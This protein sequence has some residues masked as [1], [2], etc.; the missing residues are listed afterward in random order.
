MFAFIRTGRRAVA[1]L[2]IVSCLGLSFASAEPPASAPPVAGDRAAPPAVT[3]RFESR[4]RQRVLTLW[5]TPRERGFAHGYLLADD[6][7][8]GAEYDFGQLLKPML[9]MY[10]LIVRKSLVSRFALEPREKDELD[11]L[12]EGIVA[13]RGADRMRLEA[14]GRDLD[15]ADLLALNT[16]GDWYGMGCSSLAVWGRHSRDGEPRV[17][18]NFDFPAFELVTTYALT[19]VRAADDGAAGCVAITYP[20]SIGVLTGQ[21]DR[22]VFVSVHDVPVRVAD[23]MQRDGNVPRLV[24][25]RRLLERVEGDRPVAQARTLLDSWPTMYGNNL[26]IVA[27]R[28]GD[29]EPQAGVL[30]YDGREPVDGGVSARLP[31]PEGKAAISGGTSPLIACTNDHLLRPLAGGREPSACWRYPLLLE[32]SNGDAPLDLDVA[33]LFARMSLAVFPRGEDDLVRPSATAG[34]KRSNGF[35]TL[36]QVVGEPRAGLFHV[37]FARYGSRVEREPVEVYDVPALVRAAGA[38]ASR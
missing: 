2:V 16:F 30:E 27:G 15:A 19:V 37:R 35:G 7:F 26:M 24:A 23:A 14:L 12:L 20:G 21:S 34:M 6:L 28:V 36:H 10:E 31:D 22:G 18:R 25:L 33:G 32:G 29:G 9:P 5:G 1:L 38:Q 11:G 3:G 8:A 4:G 17:G 13:R